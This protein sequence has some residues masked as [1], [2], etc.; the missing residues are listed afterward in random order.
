MDNKISYLSIYQ[1]LFYKI[2]YVKYYFNYNK[3]ENLLR[4]ILQPHF[5][6]VFKD[7]I[8]S[9]FSGKA[10]F[11]RCLHSSV[12]SFPQLTG[13]KVNC[14][15][16]LKSTEDLFAALLFQLIHIPKNL[17]SIYYI[18]FTLEKKILIKNIVKNRDKSTRQKLCCI[19]T[20]YYLRTECFKVFSMLF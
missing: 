5:K 10:S 9:W 2:N 1:D 12:V 15:F 3:L 14:Q 18:Q 6:T 4:I 19:S 16:T 8:Y 7:L 20:I 17:I 13:M 11:G